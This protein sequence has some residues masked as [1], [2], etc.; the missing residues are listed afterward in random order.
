[1]FE[2]TPLLVLVTDLE[3]I[4][5]I[6]VVLPI[7][8]TFNL[9][10]NHLPEALRVLFLLAL[11]FTKTAVHVE[12]RLFETLANLTDDHHTVLE[13]DRFLLL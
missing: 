6:G 5:A 12:V 3:K 8:S 10:Y 2:D 13:L 1:V 7:L 11:L 4:V 9:L